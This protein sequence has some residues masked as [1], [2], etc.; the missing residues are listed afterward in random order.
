MHLR[1]QQ[2]DDFYENIVYTETKLA[3]KFLSIQR[4]ELCDNAKYMSLGKLRICTEKR[5]TIFFL[6]GWSNICR[7][8]S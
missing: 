3:S 8:C 6:L 5:K 7:E 4:N 1:K 2:F